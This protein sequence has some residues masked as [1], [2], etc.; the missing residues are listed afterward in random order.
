VIFDLAESKKSSNEIYI[1]L[2]LA[3][4]LYISKYTQKEE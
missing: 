1:M 4:A 2:I 3:I